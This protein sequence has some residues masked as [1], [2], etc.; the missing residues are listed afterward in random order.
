MIDGVHASRAKTGMGGRINTIMQTCFF[1]IS[2]VLPRDEAIA[3]IKKAIEKTY[4]KRGEAVVQQELRRRRRLARPSARSEGARP[5]HRDSST[6]CPPVPTQAPDFVRDVSALMLPATAI[7]S[8]SARCLPVEPSPPAPRKWEKR[9][10]AA[11]NPV[12]DEDL[13]IQCGKCVL[14]C[15]HAV[16]R[17]KVYDARLA[18]ERARHLQIRAS[19]NGSGMDRSSTPS[20]SRPRIA[21]AASSA[22]QVC[23]AKSKTDATHKAINMAAQAPLRQPEA[24][25][26]GLLRV[27]ARRSPRDR[28]SMSQVKDVRS[29]SSRSS[30]SPAPAPAAA[31]PPTSSC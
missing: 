23:P 28:L 13:C 3:Q 31:K 7:C 4:G 22:S 5:R 8:R 18:A 12:W 9:N 1:A 21:P 25:Q 14:V 11:D 6:S 16:I 30:S 19:R 15:P 26:L 29:S 10:I 17:A 2:G 27:P 24:S 20:R